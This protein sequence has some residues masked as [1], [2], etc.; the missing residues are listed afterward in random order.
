MGSFLI[1]TE[2]GDVLE[3]RLRVHDT[4][5]LT[6][7]IRADCVPCLGLCPLSWPG[8]GLREVTLFW[9]EGRESEQGQSSGKQS[10][11]AAGVGSPPHAHWGWVSLTGVEVSFPFQ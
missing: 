3:Q 2:P 9:G 1:C 8:V 6:S 11:T 4:M 7:K 5:F 10:E